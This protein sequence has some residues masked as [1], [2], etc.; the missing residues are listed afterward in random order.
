MPVSVLLGVERLGPHFRSRGLQR[1]GLR[2]MIVGGE[3]A[4]ARTAI[5][6]VAAQLISGA[7]IE[8]EGGRPARLVLSKEASA[9]WSGVPEPGLA[10]LVDGDQLFE[11]HA[12]PNVLKP[13]PPP[14][15]KAR[16]P[17]RPHRRN[18]KP[19]PT[20]HPT[21]PKEAASPKKP[22]S[23]FKPDYR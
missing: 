16:K 6:R 17:R 10:V 4:G 8:P 20:T 12:A 3:L 23:V 2:D 22:P 15:T 14:V 9:F 11:S 13:V 5:E 21:T 19:G 1:L 7:E 18:P